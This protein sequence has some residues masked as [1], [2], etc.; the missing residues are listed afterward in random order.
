MYTKLMIILIHIMIALASLGVA[1]AT[2]FTPT[3]KRLAISYGLI[4][5][6]VASGTALLIINPSNLL[7]TCLTGLFY[8][9][10]VSIVTIATHV[11]ARHLAHQSID[12]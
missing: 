3:V 11:R 7:H 2:L 8:L 1:T 4:V 12:Q 10:V 9:T 5:A 6:T